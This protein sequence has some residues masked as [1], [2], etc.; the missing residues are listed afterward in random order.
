MFDKGN[1]TI[2]Q[3]MISDFVSKVAKDFD[4][5]YFLENMQNEK[6]PAK[7]WQTLGK[8]HYFGLLAPDAYGGS[9]FTTADLV[10][11]FE[12]LAKKG[13]LS[14]QI[15][16]QM[17]CCA[18]LTEYGSEE[19]KKT[20]L[21]RLISGNLCGYAVMEQ[22]QGTSLFEIETI[23]DKDG[24]AYRLKGAKDYVVGAGEADYFIVAARTASDDSKNSAQGIS[25]FLV[26]AKSEG[27]TAIQKELNVRVTGENEM[28]MITGDTFWEVRFDDVRISAG[29]RIGQENAGADCIDAI[30]RLQMIMMAAMSIGWGEKLLDMGIEH[31]RNRI[32]FADPIG[33]YQA[34]QHPMVRAKTDLE[35]AK[36]AVERAV[37]AY[38]SNADQEDAAVFTSIAKY[39]ATE[40][41]YNACDIAMQAHGGAAFDRDMGIIC[42]WPL[43][44]LSRMIP[45]NNDIIL[46]RFSEAA[47]GLPSSELNG[48]K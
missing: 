22:G 32:I 46:E 2:E 41:A 3:K 19:Q 36:L 27:L 10:V 23:A 42:L 28:M 33:S 8:G 30:T 44:L 35:L 47:L 38:D 21:P 12:N 39:A 13:L 9:D 25:L 40:A 4:F 31:A 34:I 48:F 37:I 16:N 29:N 14:H 20:V 18:C 6:P 15:M 1:Y 45:L 11:F 7:Y 5:E 26:D 43:I 24:D 17:L